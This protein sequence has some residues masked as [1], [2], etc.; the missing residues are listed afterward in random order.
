MG[1]KKFAELVATK[2]GGKLQV[3]EFPSNQLGTDPAIQKLFTSEVER[4]Q[5]IK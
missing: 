5:R 4:I 1:V 3:K 2:S